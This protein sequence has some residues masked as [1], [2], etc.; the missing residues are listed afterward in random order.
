MALISGLVGGVGTV[1]TGSSSS[2]STSGTTN[3]ST[4]A[5]SGQDNAA[6]QASSTQ[7][8]SQEPA[9]VEETGS[10]DT[11]SDSGTG[12]GGNTAAQTSY[13]SYYQS[14]AKDTIQA[15]RS[16]EIAERDLDKVTA[17]DWARRAAIA[18]QAKMTT[19]SLLDSMDDEPFSSVLIDHAKGSAGY[20]QPTASVRSEDRADIKA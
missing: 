19:Q 7:S 11:G 13:G 1:V 4:A 2:G 12:A 18:T 15:A 9:A 10:A 17:V 8:G 6:D 14:D 5:T 16:Y 20:G 3:G